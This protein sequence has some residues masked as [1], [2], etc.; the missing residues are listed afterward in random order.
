[1]V[2]AAEVV[3]AIEEGYAQLARLHRELDRACYRVR[4]GPEVLA[5]LL[6]VARGGDALAEL[7][8]G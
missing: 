5:T 1:M 8:K 3:A 4:F 2:R 7:L 6:A